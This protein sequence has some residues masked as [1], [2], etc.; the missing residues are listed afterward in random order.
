MGRKYVKD[1]LT[2]TSDLRPSRCAICGILSGNATGFPEYF[3][4]WFQTVNLY[5]LLTINFRHIPFNILLQHYGF[6]K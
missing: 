4:L 2:T 5:I 6:I 3:G 1:V